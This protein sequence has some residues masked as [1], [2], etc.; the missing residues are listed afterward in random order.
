VIDCDLLLPGNYFC[1][2]IFTGLPQFP[3]L[4]REV[5]TE[6]LTVTVGGALNTVIGL[7]RM[8][9]DVGW[10]GQIGNDFFSRFI[11]ETLERE[12]VD[13]RMITRLDKPFQRATVALSYPHE[14]AFISYIDPAPTPIEMVFAW[15]DQVRFRH[16]HLTSFQTDPRT[17]ALFD[18]VRER[19][20]SIS[21][22]CQDHP[23]RLDQPGVTETLSRLTVFM[24]NAREALHLTG[25]DTIERAASMLRLL[26]STLVIKDGENGAY[27]WQGDAHWHMPAI[28]VTPVDTTG[29]GDVFN[30]GFL[31]AWLDGRTVDVCLRWGT[32][33]G[34]LST[35]GKGGTSTAPR[36]EV[37]EGWSGS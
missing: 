10:I 20:A 8:G 22:D 5:Y 28:P 24:P 3:E 12:N 32:I 19:G 35:L 9:V 25:C 15:L 36:R 18:L 13:L 34:G 7:R 21:M 29:A 14:R 37:V 31:A 4:G 17:V 26:V 23:I 16:L 2:L 11:L 1:D 30:A 27:A 33:C 6:N